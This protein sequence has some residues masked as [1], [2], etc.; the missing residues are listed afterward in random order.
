VAATV[1]AVA[2][3]GGEIVERE[4]TKKYLSLRASEVPLLLGTDPIRTGKRAW[5]KARL[6][7]A[8][9][10]GSV[11]ALVSAEHVWKCSGEQFR[12]RERI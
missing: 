1:E 11:F 12:R 2:T 4:G 3:T 10:G 6:W 8:V 5:M 7:A 9:L